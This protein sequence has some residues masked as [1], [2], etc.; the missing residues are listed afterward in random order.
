MRRADDEA[1]DLRHA[2]QQRALLVCRGF[3]Y[4]LAIMIHLCPRDHGDADSWPVAQSVESFARDHVEV[5]FRSLQLP[6]THAVE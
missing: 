1:E 3:M 2:H 6:P 5:L 4:V